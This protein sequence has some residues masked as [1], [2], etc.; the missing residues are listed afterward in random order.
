MVVRQIDYI[1]RYALVDLL[2]LNEKGEKY[3]VEKSRKISLI[4]LLQLSL[5]THIQEFC[6]EIQDL[7]FFMYPQGI[8]NF[9]SKHHHMLDSLK[10][11]DENLHE[12]IH[13]AAMYDFGF[14]D[15]LAKLGIQFEKKQNTIH[16]A[17]AKFELHRDLDEYGFYFERTTTD[18]NLDNPDEVEKLL[19]AIKNL[20]SV[21]DSASENVRNF[22]IKNYSIE[23]II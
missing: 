2:S 13:A 15:L 12:D 8:R 4:K 14:L 3:V 6:E 18:Y 21:I 5:S 20:R 23:D 1:S 19:D 11:F 16:I 22:I 17:K 7:I 10:V 9:Y